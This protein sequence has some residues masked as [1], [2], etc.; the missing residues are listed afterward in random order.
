MSLHLDERGFVAGWAV[1]L[2]LFFVLLGI[3]IY[4]GTA[5]AV[6]SFQLDGYSNDVAIELSSSARED[7]ILMLEREAK[8]VALAWDAKL[9]RVELSADKSIVSV[10][11]K[12]EANTLVVSRVS[13]FSDW[14]RATSTGTIPTD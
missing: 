8:K 11:L 2:I 3:V 9:V 7:S 4:D 5:I 10:T 6:N 13:R 12:R 14:G 1:K